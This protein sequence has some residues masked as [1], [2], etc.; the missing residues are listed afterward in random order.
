MYVS[1]NSERLAHWFGCACTRCQ[2]LC[3]ICDK[4]VRN[5]V[6]QITIIV[7]ENAK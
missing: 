3:I 5:E 7:S 2:C 1:L 4:S 6:F